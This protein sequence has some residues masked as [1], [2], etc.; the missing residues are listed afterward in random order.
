MVL[1]SSQHKPS[2]PSPAMESQSPTP[3]PTSKPESPVPSVDDRATAVEE[4]TSP[5]APP[6]KDIRFW[7]I[8][9]AL[10]VS[11]F[12]SALE[13]VRSIVAFQIFRLTNLYA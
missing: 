4:L 13:L 2:L 1:A 3:L 10:C 6:K 9:V 7:L 11:T 12:L 8:F 5:G